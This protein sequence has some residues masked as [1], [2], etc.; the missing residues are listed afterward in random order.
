MLVITTN[1]T[2]FSDEAWLG[3]VNHFY[4]SYIWPAVQILQCTSSISHNA[5]LK[6]KCGHFFRVGHYGFVIAALW[7]LWKLQWH[8][9]GRDSV[10]N[11]ATVYSDA[12]QIK[13][14]SSV[15]GLCAGNSLG[16]GELFAQ[17]ASNAENVSIWWRHYELVDSVPCETDSLL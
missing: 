1:L 12:D 6:Q 16:T 9:N 13:H 14:Q 11:H 10:S 2:P 5:P 4:T 15:T 7:E 3:L 8:H 17:M